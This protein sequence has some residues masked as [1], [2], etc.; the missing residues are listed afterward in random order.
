MTKPITSVAV[1]ILVDEGKITLRDPISEYAP[2]FSRMRVLKSPDGP[3]DETENSASAITFE[4]LLTHRSGLT[5]GGFH[6]GPIGRAYNEALGGDIDSDVVPDDWI[7]RLANLPLIGQPGSAMHYER[8]TDLL[9]FLIARIEGSSLGAVLEQ[10]ILGPLGMKDTGF[11][12]PREKQHRRAAAY[13]FDE[14]G[15]LTKRTTWGGAWGNVVVSERP[16][17]MAYESG[18]R[19]SGPLSMTV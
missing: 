10:S 13:G 1:L 17:N 19:D 6:R 11:A 2:E 15:R 18:V 14:M 7:R 5:Y 16:R 4:H 8:S 12:V 9:G 3:L